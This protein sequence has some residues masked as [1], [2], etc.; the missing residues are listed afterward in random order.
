MDRQ[1]ADRQADRL[2]GRWTADR[3]TDKRAVRRMD[4][5]TGSLTNQLY[6]VVNQENLITSC[7]VNKLIKKTAIITVKL[8]TRILD[9]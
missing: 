4:R 1:T 6:L 5:Q 2:T 3:Q 7:W 9:I 8:C